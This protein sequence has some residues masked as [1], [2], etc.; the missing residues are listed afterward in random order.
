[1]TNTT[2]VCVCALFGASV[3]ATVAH[4]NENGF[5]PAGQK[6]ETEKVSEH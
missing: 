2:V 3:K 1:M 4:S 5:L 6:K